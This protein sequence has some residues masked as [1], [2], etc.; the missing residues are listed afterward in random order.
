M[1]KIIIIEDDSLIS[2]TM[3]SYLEPEFSVLDVFDS[4]E[5]F[6]IENN[7]E[8]E[9]DIIILDVILPGINGV[10]GIPTIRQFY[11]NSNIIIFT[12]MEDNDNIYKA[13]TYGAVGYMSKDHSLSEVSDILKTIYNGGS[14]MSP[15]I[16]RKILSFF[17][18]KNNNN[19]EGLT[20]RE[21]EIAESILEG[22]SY[23]MI[24][25]KH[26]ISID[27]VRKH[28]K[29]IYKKLH[30]NSKGELFKLHSK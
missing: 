27:T 19:L 10:D 15:V 28:I 24:A 29:N 9:P 17:N 1:I 12:V 18:P 25:E 2:N 14:F 7:Q 30:I 23:K 4:I 3:K 20:S 6:V 11:P 13:L 16:S 21:Q 5:K 8:L 26:A 22:L